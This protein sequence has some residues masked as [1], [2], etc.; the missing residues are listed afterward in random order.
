MGCRCSPRTAPTTGPFQFPEKLIPLMIVRALAVSRAARVRRWPAG[1]RL[2]VLGDHCSAISR[3]LEAG[4]PGQTYNIGGWN[5]CPTH[6]SC[7]RS[8]GCLGHA[9]PAR[10]RTG[11]CQCRSR[12]VTD[13]P[14]S[15]RYAIDASRIER[16]LAGAPAETFDSGIRRTVQWYLDHGD[17]VAMCRRQ[18]PG[19]DRP[20]GTA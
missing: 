9:A 4:I 5:E 17:W 20:A 18:L 11:L 16:E 8:A 2:A 13:R 1:A 14:R 3:V 7:S 10:R 6:R 15:R 12:F 19:L